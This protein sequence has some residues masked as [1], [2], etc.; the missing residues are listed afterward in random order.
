VIDNAYRGLYGLALQDK[1]VDGVFSAVIVGGF[2]Q[3]GEDEDI[4]IGYVFVSDMAFGIY[5]FNLFAASVAA[6]EDN[7]VC[8]VELAADDFNDE[9]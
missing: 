5:I 9:L 2:L 8:G 6:E 4:E 3:A 1:V 7:H